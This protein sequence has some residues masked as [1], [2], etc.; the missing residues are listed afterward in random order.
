MPLCALYN[1]MR[2]PEVTPLDWSL[3]NT[4]DE[5]KFP[6]RK[7]SMKKGR[8][9]IGQN[10]GAQDEHREEMGEESHEINLKLNTYTSGNQFSYTVQ[11]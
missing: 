4:D 10:I 8:E 3:T 9:G 7:N 5:K 1:I 6:G 11:H 2:V